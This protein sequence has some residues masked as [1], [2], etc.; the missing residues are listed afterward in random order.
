MIASLGFRLWLACGLAFSASAASAGGEPWT[1]DSYVNLYF[2]HYGGWV[3]LPH[4][5]QPESKALFDQLVDFANI[6][7]IE[8]APL[9]E[10]EKLRQL[11]VI[12]ALLGAYRAAYNNAVLVGEPLEEELNRPGIAGGRLV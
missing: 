7:R 12:L 8:Q 9:S 3:P 4:L 11:R 2:R 10:A 5:R 6:T 1:S